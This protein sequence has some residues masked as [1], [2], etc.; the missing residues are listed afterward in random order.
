LKL[1]PILKVVKVQSLNDIVTKM[2]I[3]DDSKAIL[4][5]VVLLFNLILYFNGIACLWYYLASQT[6][7]WMPTNEW[8][9]DPFVF[10]GE[11]FD[12]DVFSLSR[13]VLIAW[14]SS[15]ILITGNEIGPRTTAEIAV[16]VLILIINLI[17]SA[18]IFAQVAVFVVM[19]NR[20]AAEFQQSVDLAYTAMNNLNIPTDLQTKVIGVLI[21]TYATLDQ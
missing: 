17:I 18:N 19:S 12:E 11:Y 20:K 4:K 3:K 1:L 15:I 5:A 2:D 14:Y 10:T 7:I 6:L 8:S 9:K 16:A 21:Q 13:Q